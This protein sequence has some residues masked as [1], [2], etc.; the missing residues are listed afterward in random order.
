[1][2]NISAV[3]IRTFKHL[4]VFVIKAQVLKTHRHILKKNTKGVFGRAPAL[5]K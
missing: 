5:K 1:M 4:C 3:Q 2:N